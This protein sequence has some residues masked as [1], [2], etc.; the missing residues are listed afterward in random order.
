MNLN[1]GY[2][3]IWGRPLIV[4]LGIIALGLFVAAGAVAMLNKK[5]IR[6]VPQKWHHRIALTALAFAMVHGALALMANW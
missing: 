4:Y 1:I 2:Y 6:L 5:G 3:L